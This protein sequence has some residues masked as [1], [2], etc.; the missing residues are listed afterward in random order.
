[1]GCGVLGMV[2][3]RH[4]RP[5]T[6]IFD[7]RRV[8]VIEPRYGPVAVCR[9]RRRLGRAHASASNRGHGTPE[10]ELILGVED[11][12]E[13]IGAHG[14]DHRQQPCRIACVQRT[15]GGEVTSGYVELPDHIC[16]VEPCRRGLIRGSNRARRAA[17]TL[18]L[19]ELPGPL[20]ARKRDRR[21]GLELSR[22]LQQE[23]LH[24]PEPRRL[25]N[26]ERRWSETPH[27]WAWV[28]RLKRRGRA[29]RC[30][31]PIPVCEGR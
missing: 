3:R 19:V 6:R 24:R 31:A 16:R 11:R 26:Q 25:R 30:Q 20:L 23:G 2:G 10:E 22:T 8:P 13:S 7:S 27:S 14:V 17:V 28:L 18:D 29:D 15:G 5:P 12:H 9:H 1:M 21:L 4:E